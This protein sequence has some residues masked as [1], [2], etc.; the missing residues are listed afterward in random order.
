MTVL[1]VKDK[2]TP[3]IPLNYKNLTSHTFANLP[4]YNLSS[5]VNAEK[6]A[7]KNSDKLSATWH[8]LLA[9]HVNSFNWLA[10]KGLFLLPDS[11]SSQYLRV[12]DIEL[13][14]RLK[15]SVDSCYL[16]KPSL[17]THSGTD[18]RTARPSHF[19][20]SE[21]RQRRITYGSDFSV[22][23]KFEVFQGETKQSE[24]VIDQAYTQIPIML[25]SKLCHLSDMSPIKKVE[26]REEP[27]EP[28]GYFICNG[29]EK[30]IRLLC[31]PRRNIPIAMNRG[32]YV[33]R[34]PKFTTFG[35][36][37]R[38]VDK[39]LNTKN[40]VIHYLQGGDCRASIYYKNIPLQIPVHQL[41]IALMGPGMTPSALI[42]EVLRGEEDNLFL[43][44]RLRAWLT[45]AENSRMI[46]G[47]I[48][49]ASLGKQLRGMIIY[50]ND[51]LPSWWTFEQFGQ[52]II[53][54]CVLPHL[55]QDNQEKLRLICFMIRQAFGV[56]TGEITPENADSTANHEMLLPGHLIHA[57]LEG[58]GV[59]EL[60]FAQKLRFWI[61]RISL[62]LFF[63]WPTVWMRFS[64]AFVRT[65]KNV[66]I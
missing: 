26:I 20:P 3:I 56:G 43:A 64:K 19:Y 6:D 39:Y 25:G 12:S 62:R 18:T 8:K 58:L 36:A 59:F 33:K 24:I 9:P 37:I 42:N 11:V 61:E 1:K 38:S 51:G 45:E 40:L 22:K 29:N 32:T 35:S 31:L 57:L 27:H 34:G 5:T 16:D 44:S 54:T 65:F 49:R 30:V 47:R 2:A 52:Y 7:R 66:S 63:Y 4:D 17:P 15:I 60:A 10:D 55:Y 14:K 48:A 23:F 41:L 46:T 53:D 28:G 13:D 50:G 21:A